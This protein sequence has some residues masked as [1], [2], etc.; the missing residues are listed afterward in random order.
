MGRSPRR[1]G[2]RDLCAEGGSRQ[3]G[4]NLLGGRAVEMVLMLF[5]NLP[6]IFWSPPTSYQGSIHRCWDIVNQ[7]GRN[8]LVFSLLGEMG[9]KSWRLGV[10]IFA[11]VC[12]EMNR[13]YSARTHVSGARENVRVRQEFRGEKDGSLRTP[14]WRGP[15]ETHW[16]CN[17]V[18]VEELWDPGRSLPLPVLSSPS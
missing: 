15:D 4:H 1:G 16:P 18:E 14:L 7:R 13:R 17:H 10:S 5:I 11:H 9:H 3:V 8:H 2:A 6:S 12:K